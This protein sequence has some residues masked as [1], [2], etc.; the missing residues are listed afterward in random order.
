MRASHEPATDS[1]NLICFTTN[2]RHQ[3]S[4]Y[5]L[6]S[7]TRQMQAT[8]PGA[9]VSNVLPAV[10]VTATF[11]KSNN[12]VWPCSMST[13]G[14]RLSGKRCR[15]AD[16]AG[17]AKFAM[18]LKLVRVIFRSRRT[19]WALALPVDTGLLRFWIAPLLSRLHSTPPCRFP[20]GPRLGPIRISCHICATPT[21]AYSYLLLLFLIHGRH[22]PFKAVPLSVLSGWTKVSHVVTLRIR[23]KYPTLPPAPVLLTAS[24]LLL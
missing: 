17:C 9:E 6:R 1:K 21:P 24:L 12:S 5:R 3:R 7:H 2:F 14:I 18:V 11:G 23:T 20:P 4:S 13:C 22:S 19:R 15:V 16:E 10:G 8:T